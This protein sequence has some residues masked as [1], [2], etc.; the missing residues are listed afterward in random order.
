[1]RK[2]RNIN[3]DIMWGSFVIDVGTVW[4]SYLLA[5]WIRFRVLNGVDT[6]YVF[7][8]TM[9]SL[10]FVYALIVGSMLF[11][12][13][14]HNTMDL[15]NKNAVPKILAINTVAIL[16]LVILLFIAHIID[17]SRLALLLFWF[18]SSFL[19]ILCYLCK[20]SIIVKNWD[21]IA[22][23]KQAI[24]IGNGDIAKQYIEGVKRQELPLLYIRGY[25]GHEKKG[26]GQ[27]LGDYEELESILEKEDPDELVIAL[28]PHEARFMTDI[29]SI[30]EKEG[31]EIQLIPFFNEYIPRFPVTETVG[32]VCLINLRSTP[33]SNEWNAFVK[34][35]VD[36]VG[37]LILIVIFSPLMLVT[38]I[39]IKLTSKGPVFFCQNR[40]GLGKR[41]F[42]MYK[43]RSM[44][45]NT[46]ED[47][48]WSKKSDPRRT[49]FGSFIR[50]YSIDE[51]PQLFNVL[52]GDM[53]L[54]G[55]RPEIPYYVRQFKE[56]V[57]LYL[58]RQQVRPGMTGWAQIHG[59]RGDT[60]IE[61]R[62]KYDIWYIENWSL[63]LDIKILL[64]TVF[65]GFVNNEQL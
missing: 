28:E 63:L 23:K 27:R 35:A 17:F 43:F 7:G 32:D 53:S 49:R 5:S 46:E 45:V 15:H 39:G 1:M 58:V 57:P 55:P 4:L 14:V 60:S 9:L 48:A 65:G 64:K 18:I 47:Y 8:R 10:S 30:A 59:L 61:A 11:I 19:L 6:I 56:T 51:L 31:I 37:S 44:K 40:V 16:G 29:L 22:L 26:L 3:S 25:V 21:G 42:K 52:I 20:K 12:S 54:V 2:I 50:K 13:K 24:I 41:E 33:L 34:R 36:I 62:V 38:A